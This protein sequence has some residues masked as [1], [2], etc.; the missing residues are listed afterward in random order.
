MET[1]E[2]RNENFLIERFVEIFEST[3]DKDFG[4]L[5]RISTAYNPEKLDKLLKLPENTRIGF[6]GGEG[7]FQVEQ[8]QKHLAGA[9][10]FLLQD[11]EGELCFLV[12][13]YFGAL[14]SQEANFTHKESFNH[15][16]VL[17]WAQFMGKQDDW[18]EG[19]VIEKLSTGGAWPSY[20]SVEDGFKLLQRWI[21]WL[22]K[23]SL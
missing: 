18:L 12:T 9:I 15:P 8:A 4:T 17:S 5:G 1:T 10:D 16:L 19:E 3:H 6:E 23:Y 13:T 7:Y 11:V 14:I 2:L 20:L 22:E 21:G